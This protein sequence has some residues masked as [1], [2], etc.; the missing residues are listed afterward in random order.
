[1]AGCEKTGLVLIG[2]GVGMGRPR[3]ARGQRMW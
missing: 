2:V 1:V 3:Q